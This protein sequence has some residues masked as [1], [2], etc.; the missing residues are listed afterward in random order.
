V[1]L[2]PTLFA[3]A[4]AGPDE[5]APDA[6]EVTAEVVPV[7]LPASVAATPTTDAPAPAAPPAA[8][9]AA[10]PSWASAAPPSWAS[11]AQPSWA[12]ADP[13]A[14]AASP[15][16]APAGPPAPAASPTW[17]P[18]DAPAPAGSPSWARAER[19]VDLT[20]TPGPVGNGNAEGRPAAPD[21]ADWSG[22]WEPSVGDQEEGTPLSPLAARP[23]LSER[24]QPPSG[25]REPHRPPMPGPP[26]REG[27]PTADGGAPAVHSLRADN[28]AAY[29]PAPAAHNPGPTA[30][31]PAP[32][33]HDR[34]QAAH[35]PRLAA[36]NRGRAAHTSFRPAPVGV[37]EAAPERVVLARRVPQAHMAPELRRSGRAAPAAEPEGPAPDA[38]EA[39]AAL[40]RYQANRQAA[41]A[42]VDQDHGGRADGAGS[43]GP[44]TNGGWS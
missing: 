23:P 21:G 28:P 9:A 43:R 27:S 4:E 33:A 15:S 35:D 38:A 14:P 29:S 13:P 39:R 3:D 11:A 22:W 44:Q 31:N 25:T 20:D 10:P 18:A 41:R 36:P 1:V 16:W 34:V 5:L 30:D 32:A 26:N 2:P 6:A 12:P 7:A 37:G 24:V 42:V 8:A 17:A 19:W 40:S